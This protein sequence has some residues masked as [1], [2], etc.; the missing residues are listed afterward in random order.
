MQLWGIFWKNFPKINFSTFGNFDFFGRPWA[1]KK[2]VFLDFYFKLILHVKP[3][4]WFEEKKIFFVT[5]DFWAL[6][7]EVYTTYVV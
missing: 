3:K 2:D 7:C 6:Y 5:F 1:I 4:F